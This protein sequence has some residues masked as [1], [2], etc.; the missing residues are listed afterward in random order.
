MGA[1]EVYRATRKVPDLFWNTYVARPPAALFVSWLAPTRV[2]PDQV[3][4]FAFFVAWAAAADFV[5]YPEVAYVKRIDARKP[6]TRLAELLPAPIAGWAGR[7]E[8]LPYFEKTF[9]PHWR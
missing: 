3:T 9:P 7:I 4:L 2:T 5:L 1:V 6:E 8:S